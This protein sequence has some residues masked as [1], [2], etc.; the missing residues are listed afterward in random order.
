[1]L[2]TERN[3]FVK[4]MAEKRSIP[5]LILLLKPQPGIEVNKLL[6]DQSCE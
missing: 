5:D 4:V 2:Q 3:I 6:L 1:M